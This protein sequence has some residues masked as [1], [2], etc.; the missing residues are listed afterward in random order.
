VGDPFLPIGTKLLGGWRVA[1]VMITGGERYYWL[2]DKHGVIFLCDAASIKQ[3]QRK[4]KPD[5]T[6][7]KV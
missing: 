5:N 7:V 1:G 6:Q 3:Y 4:R 2:L